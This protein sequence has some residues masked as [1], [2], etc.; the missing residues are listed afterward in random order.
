MNTKVKRIFIVGTCAL[1]VSAFAAQNIGQ[2]IKVVG[3]GAAVKAFAPQINKGINDLAKHRDTA[4]E[5]TKV[6]PIL[7]IGVGTA[8]AIGAAQVMGPRRQVD[9]VQAVAQPS[10]DILG[11]EV[12]I[13]A[14]I[15]VSSKDVI[16]D[17][18][19]VDGVGI[20]GIVDLKL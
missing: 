19:K 10:G 5:T 16:N 14:L 3:V 15:P 1:A 9:Q 4:L 17:I 11:H 13:R 2:L 6:V 20:T 18:K 12:R 7:S 8:S